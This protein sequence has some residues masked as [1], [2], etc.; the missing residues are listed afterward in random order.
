MATRTELENSL[1]R[2]EASN[3]IT[4]ESSAAPPENGGQG[5]ASQSIIYLPGKSKISLPR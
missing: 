2:F 3:I 4:D 1:P 5:L